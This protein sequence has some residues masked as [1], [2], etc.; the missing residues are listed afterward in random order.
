MKTDEIHQAI[1]DMRLRREA[2]LKQR[3]DRS[4]PFADGQFDR[5]ERAQRLGFGQGSSIYDSSFVF[6][7]VSVG[8]NSW[9][10][11]WTLLDGSGGKVLIGDYCSISAG[12]HIYTHDTAKW[13]VSGGS[14]PPKVGTVSI[15]DNVY[16]GSQSVI[17]PGVSIGTRAAIGAN[18]FVNKDVPNNSIFAGSPANEI[19]RVH[20]N[21]KNVEFIYS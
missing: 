14:V 1:L 10:G 7:E 2:E 15:S 20:V 11:P 3:Y 9:I 6:G 21:D 5:W 4:L 13:A 12:V 16:I 17:G 8:E 19:G 18:S